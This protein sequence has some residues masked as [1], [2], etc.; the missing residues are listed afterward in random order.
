MS[1]L[2][3]LRNNYKEYLVTPK[4]DGSKVIKAKDAGEELL[5]SDMGGHGRSLEFLSG[6]LKKS[7]GS[8]GAKGRLLHEKLKHFYPKW[9]DKMPEKTSS[10][11]LGAI[12][13]GREVSKHTCFG[14]Y[15]VEALE[16]FGIISWNRTTKKLTCPFQWLKITHP[17]LLN[18]IYADADYWGV[19]YEN[20][21][22]NFPRNTPEWLQWEDITARFF[23]LKTRV[24][25]GQEISWYDL[26]A[27]AAFKTDEVP[28]PKVLVQNL[29][30]VQAVHQYPTASDELPSLIETKHSGTVKPKECDT[31]VICVRNNP[32]GDS[33]CCIRE[34]L[35]DG[36][37]QVVSFSQSNKLREEKM[38]ISIISSWRRRMTFSFSMQESTALHGVGSLPNN[39]CG[40]VDNRNFKHLPRGVF[41]A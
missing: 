40:Y 33:F 8:T 7:K 18:L 28:N 27:G 5:I 29:K 11:V 23:S 6:I 32:G 41:F 12:L 22:I 14:D 17:G 19:D 10:E 31:Q 2:D 38:S 25:H 16:Q 37:R 1:G 3:L 21:P 20:D 15:S 39:R 24:F 30:V 34:C 9:S 36:S 4:L 26:H 13:T 35:P